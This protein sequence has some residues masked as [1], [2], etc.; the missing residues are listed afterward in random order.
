MDN[1]KLVKLLFE[2]KNTMQLLNNVL[3]IA[4][5]KRKE[6]WEKDLPDL[7]D[8]NVEYACMFIFNVALGIINFWIKNDFDK[9]SKEIS[10]II[11]QLSYYGT[12]RYIYNKPNNT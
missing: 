5:I 10:N 1:K 9:D 4:Y 8:E 6:K 2:S 11:E 3:E 12:K 7:K